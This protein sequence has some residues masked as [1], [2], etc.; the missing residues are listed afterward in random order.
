MAEE[1]VLAKFKGIYVDVRKDGDPTKNLE[2]ALK[3]LKQMGKKNNLMLILNEKSHFT[4]PSAVRRDEKARAK[5]RS[6]RQ[7]LEKM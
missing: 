2:D 4:K 3:K 5:V 1:N 7:N 6:R